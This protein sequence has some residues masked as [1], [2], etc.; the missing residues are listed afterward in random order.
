M[1][2]IPPRMEVCPYCKKPF[3]RLKSHLPYCKMIGPTIPADQKVYRSKPATLPR[4]KKMKEPM[5]DVIK[6]K[7]RELET[8]SDER[9][10]KLIRDKPEQTNKSFPLL[11]VGLETSSTKKA[12]KD[13]KNQIQL[14]FKMSKKIEPKITFHGETKSQCHASENTSPKRELAK[15]LPKSKESRCTPSGTE[16]SLLV[17]SMEPSLSNQDR[18][19]SSAIPNDVQTTSVN[20]KLDK[21]DPQRQGPLGKL[22]DSPTGDFHSS[23]KNLRDEVKRVSTPLSSNES[24]SKVRDHLSEV[25]TDLRV[26]ETKEKNTEPLILGLKISPLGKIQVK[27]NQEEGLSLRVEACGSSRNAQKIVSATEMQEWTFMHHVP[28]NLSTDEATT[29]KKSQGEGAHFNL[30][31]PRET[32]YNKFLPVSQSSNQSLASLA[33]KFLQEE[34]AQ[35]CSHNPI[36]DKKAFMESKRQASVEP[37]SGCESQALHAGCQRSSHSAQHYVSKNP[38]VNHVAVAD[39]KTLPSSMGL[40][41]FPELYP[42]YLALG[43]LPGKPLYWNAEPQKLQ[44]IGPQGGRQ[45]PLL[46]RSS[47][48]K[49]SLEPPTRLTTSNFSLMRLLGAVQKGWIRGST[50]IKK[51][52]VGGITV[53]LTGSFIFCC[54]WSFRHL[55][56][57]RDAQATLHP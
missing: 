47:T 2:D 13:I 9:N 11:A 37:K 41:W 7:G 51:S 56:E 12:D 15:D 18:K 22:L 48:D 53:F 5:K 35:V 6:A 42:G 31:T 46:E 1:S 28:K 44:L 39:R 52:G 17:G 50:A 45:V 27:E 34:K 38:F 26:T 43:V 19:N 57:L 24:G 20:L 49:R 30:F 10:T 8:E 16:A 23:S 29:E 32:A 33:I 40:E 55:K 3:K 4:A 21:T 25:P 14:S 54:S 36:P